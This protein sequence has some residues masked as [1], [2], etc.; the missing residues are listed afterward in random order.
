MK[1]NDEFVEPSDL[2]WA[3][4]AAYVDGE[5][6]IL[7]NER[8]GDGRTNWGSWLR[9]II[10]NTDPRLI[11]WLKKTFGGNVVCGRKRAKTCHRYQLKWHVSCRQAYALLKGCYPYLICKK[12]QAEC[13]FAYQESIRGPGH[14]VAPETNAFRMNMRLK[15]KDLRWKAYPLE[16]LENMAHDL[17]NKEIT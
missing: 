16:E 10:C 12:D 15:L 2:D 14:R 7:I 1:T 3:R 9:L 8:N 5:G 17:K 4:L 6:S 13:A 11:L